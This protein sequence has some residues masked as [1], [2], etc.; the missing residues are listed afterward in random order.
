MQMLNRYDTALQRLREPDRELGV[1]RVELGLGYDE[2][3]GLLDKPS[4]AR[5][6]CC[7]QPCTRASRLGDGR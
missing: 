1:A 7:G 2:I 3:A 6:P 4:D 5:S